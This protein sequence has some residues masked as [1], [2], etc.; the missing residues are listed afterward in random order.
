MS[1][2][3]FEWR[4]PTK[5][6]NCCIKG[7]IMF[8]LH[9]DSSHLFDGHFHVMST[10]NIKYTQHLSSFSQLCFFL[11]SRYLPRFSILH[12]INWCKSKQPFLVRQTFHIVFLV[13]GRYS[14][15]VVKHGITHR[16]VKDMEDRQIWA[17]FAYLHC[18]GRLSTDITSFFRLFV[19]Y[20]WL[21]FDHIWAR[22]E[23]LQLIQKD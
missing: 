20:L 4:L 6:L 14:W 18:S 8:S 17:R 10:S 22:E 5:H 21:L 11:F 19:L 9:Q 12:R 23:P 1:G 3:I 2:N 7:K 13:C 15:K 16:K